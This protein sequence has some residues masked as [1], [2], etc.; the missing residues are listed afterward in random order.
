V[1]LLDYNGFNVLV[2]ACYVF[3]SKMRYKR[4]LNHNMEETQYQNTTGNIKFPFVGMPY[5]VKWKVSVWMAMS[6]LLNEM[7][8]QYVKRTNHVKITKA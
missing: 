3:S 4:S 2:K 6:S 8:I 1:Y 5:S 7:K